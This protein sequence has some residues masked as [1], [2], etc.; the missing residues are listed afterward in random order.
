MPDKNVNIPEYV[1]ELQQ[2][3]KDIRELVES[4]KAETAEGKEK[5]DK[6][7]SKADELETTNQ[8]LTSK[9]ADETKKRE[10][11]EET[12]NSFQ[13]KLYRIPGG[14]P[15]ERS[16][17]C[18]AFEDFLRKGKNHMSEDNK[19][20]LTDYFKKAYLRTD[21]NPD[22][23][24]LMPTEWSNEI[25]KQITEISE[26]RP[27][28]RVT[29]IGAKSYF[30]P[31]RTSLLASN[32]TGEAQ[33]LL[34]SIS[35]YGGVEIFPKKITAKTPISMEAI[36]DS[37]FNL[38]AEIR[39]DFGE[40]IL[41]QEGYQF[42]KGGGPTEMKGIMNNP[43]VTTV[44]STVAD[45]ITADTLIDVTGELKTGYRPLFAFNR[46]TL[47]R[48]RKFKTGTGEYIWTPTGAGG[49]APGV[50]NEINGFQYIILPDLDDIGANAFPV[51]YADFSKF[52]IVDRIGMM[53]SRDFISEADN[54]KVVFRSRKRT[55]CDITLPEAF[56]KVKCAA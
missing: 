48:I 10:E 23:G 35:Q 25:E 13:K 43:L 17:T 12:V 19:R 40:E 27:F 32:M 41:R 34:E 9:L 21:V 55:G 8:E 50:P 29:T 42:L 16:E 44:N 5:L 31:V 11:L 56:I 54:D 36:E 14:S 38:E 33:A 7:E 6:L 15:L 28:A 24:F 22:G 53:V 46:K 51:L 47:A 2:T 3:T 1:K 49:L 18:K 30:V 26:L 52:R 4:G 39:S 20:I 37:Q 45:N